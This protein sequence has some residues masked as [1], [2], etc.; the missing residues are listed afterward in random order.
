MA[1]IDV[2][3]AHGEAPSNS[4]WGNDGYTSLWTYNPANASG[5]INTAW[6]N[7]VAAGVSDI[8]IGTCYNTTGSNFKFRDSINLGVLPSGESDILELSLDVEIGDMAGCCNGTFWYYTKAYGNTSYYQSGNCMD[9]GEY[10]FIPY[11]NS[12]VLLSLTGTT[13]TPPPP[14]P[15]DGTGAK[16]VACVFQRFG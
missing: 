15:S 7:L 2:S 11:G 8:W 14:P 10:T 9:G 6:L 4:N 13:S 12:A 16:K 3:V 5:L 1:D